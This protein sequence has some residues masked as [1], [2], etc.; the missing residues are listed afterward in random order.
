LNG[1]RVYSGRVFSAKK[2]SEK[3]EKHLA[4]HDIVVAIL[5][6]ADDNIW[7]I[8]EMTAA[9]TLNKPLFILKQDD[10]TFK[11]GLLGDYEYIP[12]PPGQIT[13]TFIPMLEG[14]AEIRGLDVTVRS[15]YV[16]SVNEGEGS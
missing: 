12:F 10:V 8:Q 11:E 13:S 2:V 5:T 16:Q 3:V 7:L 4:R 6:A 1:L 9:A 15:I 14:L